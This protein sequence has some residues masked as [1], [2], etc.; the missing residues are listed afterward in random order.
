MNQ[1]GHEAIKARAIVILL[2]EFAAITTAFT[3]Q[4]LIFGNRSAVERSK[5]VC[6]ALDMAHDEAGDTAGFTASQRSKLA[7]QIIRWMRDEGGLPRPAEPVAGSD[8]A[9]IVRDENDF[10]RVVVNGNMV[11]GEISRQQDATWLVRFADEVTEMLAHGR[12]LVDTPRLRV[13]KVSPC[14]KFAVVER[15]G[16]SN[17]EWLNIGVFQ[18]SSA[19]A[20]ASVW[21]FGWNGQRVSQNDSSSDLMH[22]HHGIYQWL[23]EMLKAMAGDDDEKLRQCHRDSLSRALDH[24]YTQRRYLLA[25]LSRLE[26]EIASNEARLRTDD[27]RRQTDGDKVVPFR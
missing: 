13:L 15:I 16:R 19:H 6:T 9:E 24:Q 10:Y 7:R 21:Q 22:R 8:G 20:V 4:E 17:G 25:E 18:T 23:V 26:E 2:T 27:A 12:D 3:L 5:V 11:T 1:S 14:A